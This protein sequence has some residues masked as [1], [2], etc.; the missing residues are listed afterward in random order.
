MKRMTLSKA[1]A[2]FI[3]FM[4]AVSALALPSLAVYDTSGAT[5]FVFT[6]G[7]IAAVDGDYKSY[8]IDGTSLSI[9]GAG[10]YEVSGGCA[11]GS[12]TV[13][14]GVTGVTLILNGLTLTSSDTAPIA[15][16]KSTEVTIVAA[17]GTVNTLT[18]SA[19]NN[20]ETYPDNANA[21]NAVI[22]CKDGSR[23]TLCGTGTLNVISNGKN[24][25]K[26]G[27]TTETEGESYLTVE[28]LTLNITANV[29]DALK[30]DQELNVLSGN[31]TISAE[32]DAV[33]SDLTVNIGAA[34]ADGPTLNII[35]SCEGIEGAT[36]NIYSGD[37]T[38]R[39]SDDGINAANSD[40]T[41]YAFSLN[42]YG[43]KV[44][45]DAQ[46]DG[47]DSNGSLTLAGG[48]VE[49]Y[50]SSQNDNAPLDS[51]GTLTFGGGTVVA[52][53]SAG[54]AQTP[55][56]TSQPYVAFGAARTG[57]GN[58][59]GPGGWGRPGSGNGSGSSISIKAGD[60]LTVTDTSGNVLCTATAV[61]TASYLLFS[62]AK[63]T[64]GQTY[65]LKI[66]GNAATTASAAG[67]NAVSVPEEDEE[68]LP[69]T[70]VIKGKWYYGA[71]DYVYENGLMVGTS[72]DLF[73]ISVSSTR[74]MVAQI[75]YRLAG[76]PEVAYSGRFTDVAAG[77][78]Y[79]DACEWAAENGVFAG[80]TD[81]TFRPGTPITREQL[82]LVL[83]KYSLLSSKNVSAVDDLS[84]FSDSG[85]V[86]S[87]AE[88]AVKW[89]VGAGIISG[90]GGGI[91]D[92]GG[93]TTRAELAQILYKYLES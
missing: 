81:S 20:D 62:S 14:K 69:F 59:F 13:K 38:V 71:V 53:G 7:G 54:M 44:Y 55:N 19:Y 10:V 70:D 43:G 31:I 49:I 8:S 60:V 86:S 90:K 80:Y 12:I 5:A 83:Y 82:A 88:N 52:V 77:S 67:N 89:A 64:S 85:A 74:A 66:N 48:T 1:A 37:I 15:C 9:K 22:K 58:G 50:G 29:N 79:A 57:G 47:V 34:N 41:G 33:K 40:L 23:V 51:D 6:D 91:L 56:K 68:T 11:D 92:P 16:N 45:V 76:S 75:L 35:K 65:V 42:V 78:W 27:A 61:R 84:G 18:D 26:G 30:S 46:G 36:V 28:E 39:A 2:V 73:G 17:E 63:L 32:D 21:E 24:G 3:A 25:I 72:T 93:K 4:T 87:W